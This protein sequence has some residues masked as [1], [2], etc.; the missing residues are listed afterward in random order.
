MNFNQI[1]NIIF[2]L[3][4]VI[5][6]IDFDL[7]YRAFS[8]LT[9][10]DLDQ[11]YQKFNALKL[12]ERYETGELSDEQ[13]IEI[14]RNELELKASNQQIIDAWNALLL[15]IPVK[16]VQ[17]MQDLAKKYRLFILSNTSQ[18][19]II[20]V[21][22]ILKEQTGVSDLK[23]LVEH[24]YYSYDMGLRKPNPEIYLEVLEN[25]NLLVDETLFLDD[26]LDNI[27]AA[28]KLGIHCIH[29]TD[30][31]MCDYLKGV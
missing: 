10:K 1:K 19:H 13:F 22:R 27:I 21:N 3:G 7:T 9:E 28:Q 20:D 14:L 25:S 8:K 16:R 12:W 17:K 15:D 29:V 30:E 26:N 11:V 24:A 23:D 31:D 5:I 6:N 18:L 4:N 2:D